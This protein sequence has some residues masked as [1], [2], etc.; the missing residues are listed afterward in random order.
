VSPGSTRTD[1][2]TESARIYDLDT[3]DAFAGHQLL[4]RILEPAE[5]AAVVTWLCSPE[6]GCVT[7][8]VIHADG[9]FLP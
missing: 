3:V 6:S 9:G 4:D 5:V 8:S 7:G 2:L 1:L